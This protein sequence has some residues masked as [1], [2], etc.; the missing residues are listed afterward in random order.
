M[1]YDNCVKVLIESGVDM[2]KHDKDGCTAMISAAGNDNCK[3]VDL[4]MQ[5]GADV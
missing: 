1:G 2:N 3:C 4:L 5:A